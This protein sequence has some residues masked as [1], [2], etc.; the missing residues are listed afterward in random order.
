LAVARIY[1]GTIKTGQAVSIKKPSGEVRSGKVIKMFGYKGLQKTETDMAQAGDIVLIAG[2]TDIFIGETICDS[3]DAQPLPAI[4]IDEPTI[5]L[6]F[7]VNNS[8]F[9]GREGKFVT[10]RQIRERLVR[11]LEVN[12][13][14]ES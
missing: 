9:A 4:A 10:T 2:L 14:L 12:V 5:T 3:A 13:G 6:N 1:E 7:L 8:P 11:E